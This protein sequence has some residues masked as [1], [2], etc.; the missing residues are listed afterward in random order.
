MSIGKLA[1]AQDKVKG[2]CDCGDEI[3]GSVK[4]MEFLD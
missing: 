2:T 4:C 1:P 3:L